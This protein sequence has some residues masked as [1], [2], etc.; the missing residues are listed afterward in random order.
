MTA[1][2]TALLRND[3]ALVIF[4][5]FTYP[6]LELRPS[7]WPVMNSAVFKGL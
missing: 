4:L 1:G 7:P 6:L 5:I 3:S 2:V